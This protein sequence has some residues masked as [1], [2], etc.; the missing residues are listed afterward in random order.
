MSQH[1][2]LHGDAVKDVAFTVNDC[3]SIYN[4]AIERGAHSVKPPWTETDDF[5]SVKMAT[6]KTYGDLVHTFVE[7]HAY[8]GEFLPGFQ[9]TGS[10]AVLGLLP[11]VGL[12]FIDHCV[13][14]Q[15]EDE[16]YNLLF[17]IMTNNYCS[18]S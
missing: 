5:G 8:T 14:N 6:V 9:K 7:R 10:D 11:E 18:I 4:K 12:Q 3:N 17:I 1:M 2:S 15:P 16:M 13:G